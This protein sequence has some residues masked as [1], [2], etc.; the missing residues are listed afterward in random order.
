MRKFLLLI[1]FAFF[2]A[3]PVHGQEL[4]APAAP[5]DAQALM[6]VEQGSF[7]DDLWHLIKEAM[8]ILEPEIPRCCGICLSLIAVSLLTSVLGCFPGN[9]KSMIGLCSSLVVACL[10]FS[11]ASDLIG[12]AADTVRELSEYGKLLLPVLTAALAAQGGV[13]ES[14]AIYAGTALFDTVLT[15]LIV[16]V[17]IPLVYMFLVLAIARSA[18]GNDLIKRLQ[19]LAN[20]ASTWFLK[21]IL[22]VFTGYI[23]VTKVISGTTDQT[24]LKATKLTISG[25]VPVVGGIL[26]DASEAVLISAGVVKNTVGVYGL[27]AILAITIGPFLKIG[28]QYILLKLTAA[29]CNVFGDKH[30]TELIGDFSKA[31]GLILAMTGT[32]CL[33]LLISIVCFLK[34]MG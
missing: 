16:K 12:T 11:S 31:L 32:V 22:Y 8:S 24:A 5:D 19:E 13:T 3:Q 10:L 17:L 2:L 6:P 27:L 29:V 7:G 4:T 25:M 34:G 14:A 15:S 30:T 26:S 18:L 21:M 1:F 23:T 9:T 33:I 28:L 20:W